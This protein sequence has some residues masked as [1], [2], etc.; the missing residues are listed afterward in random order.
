MSAELLLAAHSDDLQG[1]VDAL[2]RWLTVERGAWVE[3]HIGITFIK[4]PAGIKI[5]LKWPPPFEDPPL[6]QHARNANNL[7]TAW[8]LLLFCRHHSD[9]F[10]PTTFVDDST[11]SAIVRVLV[12]IAPSYDT[13]PFGPTCEFSKEL[14]REYALVKQEWARLRARLPAYITERQA[15]LDDHCPLIAPLLELIHGYDDPSKFTTQELWA[16][17][18]GDELIPFPNDLETMLPGCNLGCQT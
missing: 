1:I 13:P 18:L 17:G 3:E 5:P 4:L 8:G 12:K 16:T 10:P 15:L 7:D 9:S 6:S 11:V 2:E 14:L